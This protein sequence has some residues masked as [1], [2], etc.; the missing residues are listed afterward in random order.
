M[1]SLPLKKIPSKLFQKKEKKEKSKEKFR[2]NLTNTENLYA[3]NYVMLMEKI[4][5]LNKWRHAVFVD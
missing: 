2:C 3:E 1:V 4:K 5:D